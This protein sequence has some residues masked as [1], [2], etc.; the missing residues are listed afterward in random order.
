MSAKSDIENAREASWHPI[1]DIG[2]KLGL[3]KA[4]LVPLR[5]IHHDT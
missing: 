4:S 5:S 1:R 3:S 2:N